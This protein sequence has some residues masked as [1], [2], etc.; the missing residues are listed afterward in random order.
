MIF[1]FFLGNSKAMEQITGCTVCR[2]IF[3]LTTEGFP[4]VY[5]KS[6]EAS[7]AASSQWL[8]QNWEGGTSFH[9]GYI[10]PPPNGMVK[11]GDIP[12]ESCEL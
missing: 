2:Y 5:C 7:L 9:G 10:T 1:S 11:S 4:A 8:A 3:P 12:L 6:T